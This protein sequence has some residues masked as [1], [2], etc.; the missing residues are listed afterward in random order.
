MADMHCQLP[1]HVAVDLYA[2]HYLII[3]LICIST[4]T[5]LAKTVVRA[6]GDVEPKQRP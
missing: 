5:D 3:L 4:A 6:R 2:D 1:M